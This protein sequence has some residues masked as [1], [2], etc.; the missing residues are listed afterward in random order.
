MKQATVYHSDKPQKRYMVIIDNKIIYFGSPIHENYTI[1]KNENRKKLYIIRHSRN[2][3]FKDF[4]SAGFWSRYL[5]WE[6][7]TLKASADFIKK[8][9][10]IN[11]ILKL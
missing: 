7:E 10:D 9:F 3:N 2:E 8:H 4:Y 1:H 5:L 6:K 11:V